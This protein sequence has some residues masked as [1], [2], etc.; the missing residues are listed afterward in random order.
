MIK[1]LFTEY[2]FATK[3]R[4]LTNSKVTVEEGTSDTETSN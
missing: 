1:K 4:L 2:T 3:Y